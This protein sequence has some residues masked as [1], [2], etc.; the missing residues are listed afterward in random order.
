MTRLQKLREKLEADAGFQFA[1]TEDG[2]W[3]CLD[4]TKT[5]VALDK[6]LGKCIEKAGALVGEE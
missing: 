2:Q 1:K 4:D 6:T 3:A 5:I